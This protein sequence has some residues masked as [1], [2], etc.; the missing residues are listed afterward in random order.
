MQHATRTA[1]ATMIWLLLVPEIAETLP[2]AHPASP[3]GHIEEFSIY[4]NAEPASGPVLP[5]RRAA[6]RATVN[7]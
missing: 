6:F 5:M 7:P 3:D 4:F 2:A 1:A